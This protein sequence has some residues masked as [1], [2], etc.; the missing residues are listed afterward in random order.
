MAKT[1]WHYPRT[2]FARQVYTLLADSPATAVSLFGPRRTGKTEFLKEDL[3]PLAEKKGH[4]VVYVSLW[5]ALDAPLASLLFA[6]DEA[7]R[8]GK[9]MDR[10]ATAARDLAP[11][12]KLKPPGTG[13]EIE[14]D[15]AALKGRPEN[16][17]LLLLDQYCGRL[18]DEKKPT[19]LLF[20]EFQEIA[21]TDASAPLVRCPAHESRYTP[22]KP[23]V[24]IHGVFAGRAP[25]SFQRPVCTFLSFCNTA[26]AAH[27]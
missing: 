27:S 17:H 4:R 7:L 5:Q 11:K 19:L 10:L 14:I 23:R 24:R 26:D 12:L 13:A 25:Q 21:R 6:M 15:V 20:D 3:A 2:D 18:A 16:N 22:P 9:L 8:G 1:E